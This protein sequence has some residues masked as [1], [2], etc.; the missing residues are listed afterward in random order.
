V[1]G[2]ILLLMQVAAVGCSKS[3]AT[4]GNANLPAN[5][6]APSTRV[7]TRE[8]IAKIKEGITLADA[9]AVLGKGSKASAASTPEVD[10]VY[11]WVDS[12]QQK[13]RVG[14]KNGKVVFVETSSKS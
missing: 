4:G 9:E 1:I 8:E 2:A 12:K 11:D 13:V 6:P 14:L 10:E 7:F 5:S 3:P